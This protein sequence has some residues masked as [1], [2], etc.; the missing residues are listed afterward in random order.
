MNKA[1][2][3]T[4]NPANKFGLILTYPKHIDREKFKVA[5][6]LKKFFEEGQ[7]DKQPIIEHIKLMLCHLD[8][9]SI[10]AI[11]MVVKELYLSRKTD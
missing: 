1:Q 8:Y 11:Y 9:N 5:Q 10:R 3:D 2:Y 4:I 7:M 6:F